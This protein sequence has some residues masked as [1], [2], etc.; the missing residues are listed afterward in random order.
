[1]ICRLCTSYAAKVVSKPEDIDAKQA[2]TNLNKNM[3]MFSLKALGRTPADG[4]CYFP[5]AVS[6]CRWN[7]TESPATRNSTTLRSAICNY[8]QVRAHHV[9]SSEI[10]K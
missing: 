4:A 7:A 10:I 1:M 3:Q 8:L 9:Q 5:A 2:R 6:Q